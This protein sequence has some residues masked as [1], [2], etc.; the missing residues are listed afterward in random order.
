MGPLSFDPDVWL[1]TVAA[2]R[3]INGFAFAWRGALPVRSD[4]A[5]GR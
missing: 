3:R 1:E 5:S 2:D 4:A